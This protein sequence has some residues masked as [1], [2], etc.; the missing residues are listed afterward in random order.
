MMSIQSLD[1]GLAILSL[2]GLHG[3]LSASAIAGELGVHQSSASRLLHSLVK[4]GFVRKP[5]F[6][7]F[8]LDYGVLL[9][10]GL[11]M[12]KFPAVAASAQVCGE[13][14]QRTGFGAAVA[15]LQKRRLLFLA[16]IASG[17]SASLQLLDDSDYPVHASILGLPLCLAQGRR[18]MVALLRESITRNPG[19]GGSDPVALADLAERS[20]KEHGFFYL[21]RFLTHLFGAALPFVVDG[22][23]AVLAIFSASLRCPPDEARRI[24]E[25]G[26]RSIAGV[27]GEA[28]GGRGQASGGRGQESGGRGQESGDKTC[29]NFHWCRI[30]RN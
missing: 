25:E 21:E 29:R 16:R 19:R 15:I 2:L 1:R 18:K 14:H 12:E 17:A 28:S 20:V 23:T 3:R 26:I 7:S 30:R 9:F 24:L 5:D 8:A 4:A 22:E 13:I 10:A 6:R 11:A 27:R